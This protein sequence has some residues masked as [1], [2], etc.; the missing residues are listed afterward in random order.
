MAITITC[1]SKQQVIA[2]ESFQAH[3]LSLTRG[4]IFV[5]AT[6]PHQCMFRSSRDVAVSLS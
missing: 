4:R 6:T 5:A 2:N 1:T 3:D